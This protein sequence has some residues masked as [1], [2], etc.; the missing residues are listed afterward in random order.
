MT[1]GTKILLAC[2]VT[3]SSSIVALSKDVPLADLKQQMA[4]YESGKCECPMQKIPYF[5]MNATCGTAEKH[6]AEVTNCQIAVIDYNYLLL[7]YH[8]DVDECHKIGNRKGKEG[9]H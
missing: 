8:Q 3:C 5:D 7:K 6:S 4:C 9:P 2:A 1:I